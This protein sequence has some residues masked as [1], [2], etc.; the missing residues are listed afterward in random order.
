MAKS[1]TFN[2][3]KPL[4]PP[5]TAWDK[6]Y[7]WIVD[8]ARYV[9]MVTI[10]L[11]AAAF[12]AKVIVDTDAK[13]KKKQIDSL[14]ER[15]NFYATDVEPKLRLFAT[16]EDV[17]TKLW[18]SSS[19]SADIIKEIYSYVTNPGAD[20]T[21]KVAD[22]FVSVYG[23]EDLDLLRSLE[24]SL[25]NSPSFSSVTFSNL[26]IN[27]QDVQDL[28]GDYVLTAVIKNNKRTSLQ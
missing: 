8:K 26:T 18:D 23:T 17:Y 19:N 1:V 7:D 12:V 22:G 20:L 27:Q 25:R 11:I 28:K 3:L 2:L 9:V 10:I 16:K 15:L 5:K 4:Q 24:A 14:T 13:N 6:I 21:I